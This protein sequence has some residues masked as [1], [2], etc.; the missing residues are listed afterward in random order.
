M[1]KTLVVNSFIYSCKKT[2][3]ETE[4]FIKSIYI[5]LVK[6]VHLLMRVHVVTEL[7][8]SCHQLYESSYEFGSLQEANDSNGN[9]HSACSTGSNSL[10]KIHVSLLSIVWYFFEPLKTI[11]IRYLEQLSN[12]IISSLIRGFS[13]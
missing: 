3:W 10:Q 6:A 4:K 12:N 13:I 1:K 8:Q 11:N 9:C 5:W 2:E 7:H